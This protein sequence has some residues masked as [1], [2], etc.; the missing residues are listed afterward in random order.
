MAIFSYEAVDP[1]GKTIKGVIEAG[2]KV[3]AV[4]RLKLKG[5]HAFDVKAIK[6]QQ[7]YRKILGFLGRGFSDKDL[8]LVFRTIGVLVQSG[9]PIVDAISSVSE[10]EPNESLKVF[11]SNVGESVKSGLSLSQSLKKAGFDNSLAINLILAGEESN[12]LG[13]MLLKV[14]DAMERSESIREN[15]KNALLYP[16]A[17][18]IVSIGVLI[19]MMVTVVPKIQDI[20][21]TMKV[22]LPLSTRIVIG[23]S[24]VIVNHDI[25]IFILSLLLLIGLKVT[26]KR[27]TETIDRLKLKLPIFGRILLLS[28]LQRF[29]ETIS[30]LLSSGLTLTKSI[31]IASNTINNLYI[32]KTASSINRSIE[33]GVSLSSSMSSTGI[34]PMIS[35]QI[36]RAGEESGRL[37]ELLMKLS[38][39]FDNDVKMFSKNLTTLLEPVTIMIVGGIVGFI[40]FSLMLPIVEISV[41]K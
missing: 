6:P 19:F 13:D 20:Y 17:I 8:C 26:S 27:Y 35:V 40:I 38:N 32:R 41:V 23:I 10:E 5:I 12:R 24:D 21:A 15:V 39:I 2:T 34:F 7:K 3:E 36:A 11:L 29:F 37:P 14:S 30:L 16:T 31:S 1:S 22:S 33:N 9:I 4:S 25:L 28:N 18:I